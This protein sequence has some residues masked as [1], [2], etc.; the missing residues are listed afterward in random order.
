MRK[1]TIIALLA[2]ATSFSVYAGGDE[3]KAKIKEKAKTECC[4]KSSCCP[5]TKATPKCCE[6]KCN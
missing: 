3:K 4:N 5:T 2:L 1:A 6:K